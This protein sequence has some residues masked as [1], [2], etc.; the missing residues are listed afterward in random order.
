MFRRLAAVLGYEPRRRR[1]PES[2]GHLKRLA[3][4]LNEKATRFRE[5]AGRAALLEQRIEF[6]ETDSVTWERRAARVR[7]SELAG[8]AERIC[9]RL[10]GQMQEATADL[11][12][13]RSEEAFLRNLLTSERRGFA[14][15]VEQAR[16]LG[17]DVSGCLLFVDL[18]RPECPADDAL[19]DDTDA[20][21]IGR[22]IDAHGVH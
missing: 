16:R 13:L 20:D 11:A 18:T 3:E 22:V 19:I 1:E 15:M 8:D 17:H 10:E 12:Q 2:V 4:Q 21:F 7:G 5:V 9:G 6:L 14:A